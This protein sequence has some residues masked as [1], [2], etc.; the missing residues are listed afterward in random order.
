MLAILIERKQVLKFLFNFDTEKL[1]AAGGSDKTKE[2]VPNE[3]THHVSSS[4]E[5]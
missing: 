2:K 1:F 4:T 5:V 3:E